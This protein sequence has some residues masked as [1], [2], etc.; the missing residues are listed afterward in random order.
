VFGRGKPFQPILTT[1]TLAYRLDMLTKN[2]FNDIVNIIK[3]LSSLTDHKS[4]LECLA[5]AK[6]LTPN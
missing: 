4:K 5:L 1:D 3:L 6:A 2:M